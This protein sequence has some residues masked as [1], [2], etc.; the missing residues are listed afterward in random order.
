MCCQ[1]EL[2]GLI[3]FTS[4]MIQCLFK[5][6]YITKD[7]ERQKDRGKGRGNEGEKERAR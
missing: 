1:G 3:F 2:K 5:D 7:I 6:Y 4:F